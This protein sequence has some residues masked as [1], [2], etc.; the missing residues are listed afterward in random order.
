MIDLKDNEMVYKR[1]DEK[2]SKFID[3]APKPYKFVEFIVYK[4]GKVVRRFPCNE[5][6][7]HLDLISEN[8][9]K[10]TNSVVRD[11][12]LQFILQS[13]YG[14]EQN[15]DNE[16]FDK[17]AKEYWKDRLTKINRVTIICC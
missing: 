7:R 3:D 5:Y 8:T 16:K 10:N 6:E 9:L 13:G 14:I 4:N 11:T 2:I 17:I 15:F 12:Y 1:F